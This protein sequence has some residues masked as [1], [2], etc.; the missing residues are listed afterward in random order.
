M[1][2]AGLSVDVDSVASHLEGYGFRPS[3]DD[4]AAYT[5]A[6]PRILELLA[7]TG[8]R[9]TF[10]LIAAEARGHPEEIARI[11]DEGHEVASHSMT[12]RVPFRDLDPETRGIELG[13]SKALLEDLAGQEVRGFRAPSWDTGPW[14]AKE[15]VLA[16]YR[17][18]SSA[19]PSIL[20][21]FR[22]A[23]GRRG[24][25]SNHQPHAPVWSRVFG[26][27]GLHRIET[28]SGSLVEVP[29]C[30]TPWLRLP[31]YHTLQFAIPDLLFR[32]I[33][34]LAQLRGEHV[35]YQ[36]HA[37]DFLSLA[38]DRLDQRMACHPGMQVPLERKLQLAAE[39]VRSL[40]QGR[41][42]VPLRELVAH[43]FDRVHEAERG[44]RSGM[45]VDSWETFSGVTPRYRT[46]PAKRAI[47][48]R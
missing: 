35:W 14:L 36:F 22:R 48:R 29:M 11:M 13:G 18:D 33:R 19:Y 26:P 9:A 39:A 8:A 27:G 40:G 31:Y 30:T 6:I 4:G 7:R 42:V 2:P 3:P 43:R 16:G 44:G 32:L 17:Y 21:P 20:L 38:D 25:R 24:N 10:F 12:H 28:E 45:S 5:L 46:T 34:R 37:A 47:T 41:T 1:K 23:A 15:L